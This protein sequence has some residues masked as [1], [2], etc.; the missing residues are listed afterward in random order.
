MNHITFI[1]IYTQI[2]SNEPRTEE[3]KEW[4]KNLKEGD[5]I[6]VVKEDQNYRKK[7]WCKAKID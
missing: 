3:Y 6:D 7:D 4:V 5:I 1:K 2:A